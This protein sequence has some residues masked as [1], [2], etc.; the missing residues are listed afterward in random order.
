MLAGGG[1]EDL[2]PLAAMSVAEWVDHFLLIDTG[3]SAQQ[4]IALF[5]K[6]VPADQL[7]VVEYP[8]TE[9][10]CANMRNF[11]VAEAT[12]LEF[13]WALVLDTDYQFSGDPSDFVRATKADIVCCRYLGCTA[14]SPPLPLLLRLPASGRWMGEPHEAFVQDSGA[15][16]VTAPGFFVTEAPKTPEQNHAKQEGVVRVIKAQAVMSPRLYYFLGDALEH[17]ERWAEARDAWL[18]CANTTTWPEERNWCYYRLAAMAYKQQDY[19]QAIADAYEGSRLAPEYPEF[20]WIRAVCLYYLGLYESAIAAAD[21][22]E[23]LAITQRTEI[24]NGWGNHLSWYEG[25]A[26]V[27]HYCYQDMGEPEKA[28]D[29][30][31]NRAKLEHERLNAQ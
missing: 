7:T 31:S 22:A 15:E 24:R 3:E 16:K 5:R 12:R 4:T 6:N 1:R 23:A 10:L 20:P 11:A 27:R 28:R 14:I 26:D 25:P 30:W 21:R 29:E 17:L 8:H 9:L 13:G 18:T 19:R 2:A